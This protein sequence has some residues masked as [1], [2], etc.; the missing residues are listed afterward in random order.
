MLFDTTSKT[1]Y[2]RKNKN[3]WQKVLFFSLA[4]TVEFLALLSRADEDVI[5][6]FMAQVWAVMYSMYCYHET[7]AVYSIQQDWYDWHSI[8]KSRNEKPRESYWLK[9]NISS[10]LH[11]LCLKQNSLSG[12]CHADT[13]TKNIPRSY[14]AFGHLADAF[15]SLTC[16]LHIFSECFSAIFMQHASDAGRFIWG[17]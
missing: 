7:Q 5:D 8:H 6:A 3:A 2:K 11:E 1:Y 9:S 10:G 17:F 15:I 13:Q 16:K 14:H 12:T 4:S